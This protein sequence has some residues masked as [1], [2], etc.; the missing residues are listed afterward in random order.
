MKVRGAQTWMSLRF[1]AIYTAFRRFLVA[2]LRRGSTL[3]GMTVINAAEQGGEKRMRLRYA[4]VCRCCG[5]SWD[6]GSQAIYERGT[7]SVRCLTCPSRTD[8]PAVDG[9]LPRPTAS[10]TQGLL[11]GVAGSSARREFKRRASNR[12]KRVRAA[13][14]RLGGLL[15]AVF[16]DPQTTR[17]W[18]TGA[19]GEEKVGAELDRLAGPTVRV[20]HDRRI[21]GARANIDHIVVCPTGV[22]VIDAKK[23]AGRPHLCAEG[24]LVR[25]RTENLMVGSR[26]CSRLLD[27]M[28]SQVGLVTDAL[29]D[30]P[31]IP[32]S[33]ILCF[34]DAEWPLFGGAFTTRGV[35]VLWPKKLAAA[36]EQ[37]GEWAAET[38]EA[39]HRRLA[40]SFPPA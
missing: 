40:S 26:D 16:K 9:S 30:A 17:A 39:V 4:G 33:G 36:I 7:R 12:E 38:I 20:L 37:P 15:L 23:Y 27:S 14:P 35:T 13:H 24:G 5:A 28:L 8:E 22:L 25:E 18:A 10:E 2:R 6:A 34:V 1:E 21:R 3:S 31:P 32:A 29:G 19:T 11:L